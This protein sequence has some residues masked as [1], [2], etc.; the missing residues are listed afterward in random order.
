MWLL[1]SSRADF[2]AQGGMWPA[3]TGRETTGPLGVGRRKGDPLPS[4]LSE[5]LW[6]DPVPKK[7]SV[8]CGCE[9]RVLELR[10]LHQKGDPPPTLGLPCEQGLTSYDL[11]KASV[12]GRRDSTGNL[13]LLRVFAKYNDSQTKPNFFF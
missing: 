1:Q 8:E 5:G 9:L 11:K 7:A 12:W 6:L 2:R 4:H 10:Q 13:W 3:G